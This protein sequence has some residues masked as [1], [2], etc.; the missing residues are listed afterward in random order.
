MKEYVELRMAIYDFAEVDI[1]TYSNENEKDNNTEDDDN[2]F[3][4]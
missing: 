4:N 1:I 2:W 3:G